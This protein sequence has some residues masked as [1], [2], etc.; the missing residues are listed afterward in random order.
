MSA[1]CR[2]W[3]PAQTRLAR[4][5]SSGRLPPT[6]FMEAHYIR[7][8]FFLQPGQLLRGA[9]RLKGI[10]GTIVQGRYDLLCPPKHAYALS[11]AW[12]DAH[13]QMMETAGH[14]MSEPGVADAMADAVR[15]LST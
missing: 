6:P 9:G 4:E 14:C 1:R 8:D 15:A 2:S 12:P 11:Q 7:N 3:H 13:L 10:P 5:D